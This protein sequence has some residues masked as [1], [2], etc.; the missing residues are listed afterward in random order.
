MTSFAQ[1]RKKGILILLAA[2]AATGWYSCSEDFNVAAPYK[3]VTLV[4]GLLN[5]DDT[6]HYIRIQKAF[7]DEHKSALNMAGEADSS[8]YKNLDVTVR[9]LAGSVV[10]QNIPLER[11]NL[12]TE[13]YVK[14]SGSF[15]RTPNYAYKFKH[16]LNPNNRYRVVIQHPEG[17]TDSSEI[18]IINA[19]QMAFIISDTNNFFLKFDRTIPVSNPSFSYAVLFNLPASARFMEVVIRFH[20][21]E[22]DL[23]TG[24]VN[25]HVSDFMMA[26]R[27]AESPGGSYERVAVQNI[28]FYSFLRDA[29][30]EVPFHIERYMDSSD[31][32]VYAG[33]ADFLNYINTVQ[34]QST[35]LTADQLKPTYTNI[36]GKDVYG[37]FTS[38]AELIK[39]KVPF[40]QATIDS[41]KTNP[42]T[43]GVNIK[44]MTTH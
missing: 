30:Q 28:D 1:I 14:D 18:E 37:I 8:F 27:A 20:W 44:G 38:R 13:G 7:L 42:I 19:R 40:D 5:M 11:V 39:R 3:N 26:S 15:F 4:Y 29:M 33:G 25:R 24:E 10:V 36:H 17:N 2:F 6:A 35:G 41:L 22:K 21:E 9:E 16:V 32:I 43:S 34:V 23:N 12:V 31:V